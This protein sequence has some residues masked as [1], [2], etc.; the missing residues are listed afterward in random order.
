MAQSSTLGHAL[1]TAASWLFAGVC[2]VGSVVYFDELRAAGRS[3]LGVQ[4][5]ERENQDM[6]ARAEELREKAGVASMPGGSV[7]LLVDNRGHYQATAQ[8]NGSSVEVL[9]DT[10]ATNVA[11]TYEDAERAG[12]YV[13]PQDF[14]HRANTANGVSRI[15]PVMIDS[16]SIGSITVRN[17]RGAVAERGKLQETLLGMAFLGRLSRAEMS[18][19]RLL[20][21][22]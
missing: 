13:R 3:L 5:I 8:I 10:G 17:V 14:T 1:G 2:M 21:Q 12:I 6:A 20:L 22:E 16:I 15:A 18:R 9:V 7:E 11:L 4:A 19:G